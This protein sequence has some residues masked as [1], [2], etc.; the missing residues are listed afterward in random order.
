M[1]DP[2]ITHVTKKTG[3]RAPAPFDRYHNIDVVTLTPTLLKQDIR[4]YGRVAQQ[5]AQDG[6]PIIGDWSMNQQHITQ[7][8]LIDPTD[9]LDNLT[10][11]RLYIRSG[12]NNLKDYK[13][14]TNYNTARSHCRLF[15][16]HSQ[17][18]AEFLVKSLLQRRKVPPRYTHDLSKLAQ[19]MRDHPLMGVPPADWEALAVRIDVLDQFTQT[20]HQAGYT[21]FLIT[22]DDLNRAVHR[23]SHTVILFLDELESALH[24]HHAPHRMGLSAS[25]LGDSQHQHILK[26]HAVDLLSQ[27]QPLVPKYRDIMALPD[28]PK[29]S[30]SITHDPVV[31]FLTHLDPLKQVMTDV[32]PERLSAMKREKTSSY[33]VK[34][35]L[36]KPPSPVD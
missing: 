24:P 16:V 12:L 31:R 35:D 22:D 26:T 4:A 1:D 28:T 13:R 19:I 2:T 30:S 5:I 23:L 27:F 14:E 7:H 11:S 34:M 15:I 32:V 20:D 25:C 29:T 10:N 8:A 9:W 36:T 6:Q 3:P 21:T 18:A 17:A 33:Y